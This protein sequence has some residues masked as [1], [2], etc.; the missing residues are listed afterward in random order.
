MYGGWRPTVSRRVRLNGKG[1]KEASVLAS[2]LLTA[3]P[4]GGGWLI[5][6]AVGKPGSGAVDSLDDSGSGSSWC[7]GDLTRDNIL[8]LA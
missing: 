3:D 8:K 5:E 1:G 6:R 7:V 2:L 4:V